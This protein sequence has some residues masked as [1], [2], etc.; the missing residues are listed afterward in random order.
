MAFVKD[1]ARAI[2]SPAASLLSKN[3]KKSGTTPLQPT[4]ISTTPYER[5]MSL[6]QTRRG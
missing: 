1:T 2:I 5:P 4:M 6:I 3:K